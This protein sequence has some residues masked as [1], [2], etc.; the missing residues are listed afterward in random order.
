MATENA[1]ELKTEIIRF[2]VSKG[3]KLRAQAFADLYARG[4][5]DKK[6]NLSLFARHCLVKFKPKML[7][8]SRRK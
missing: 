3:E 1:K 2:R 5:D 4:A 6:G 7:R 8:D